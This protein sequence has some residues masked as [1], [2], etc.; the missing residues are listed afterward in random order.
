MSA[1][2]HWHEARLAALSFL[3]VY[4][5]LALL[6]LRREGQF[7]R[8]LKPGER[9][10]YVMQ[11]VLL[12]LCVLAILLPPVLSPEPRLWAFYLIFG[13]FLAL[14]AIVIWVAASRYSY[15]WRLL[16]QARYRGPDSLEGR[17]ADLSKSVR[18]EEKPRD[19]H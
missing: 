19:E 2:M 3:A 7:L 8:S 11:D 5:V 16:S 14:W 18:R 12:Q 13:A 4:V 10:R 1:S 6:L 15:T 9:W 17:K